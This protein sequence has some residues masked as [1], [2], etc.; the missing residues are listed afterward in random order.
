LGGGVDIRFGGTVVGQFGIRVRV[1]PIHQPPTQVRTTTQK[2]REVGDV[3]AGLQT[4]AAVLELKLGT[5]PVHRRRSDALIEIPGIV[6][7]VFEVDE[8]ELV[9]SVLELDPRTDRPDD[10]GNPG[11]ERQ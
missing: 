4:Q 6:V 8:I 1:P 10:V 2:R 5:D 11:L 9:G 3:L 7:V